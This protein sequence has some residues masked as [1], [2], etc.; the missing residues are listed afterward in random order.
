[1][2][3]GD[4]LLSD[5]AI[6]FPMATEI[7]RKNRLD[8]CCGGKQTLKDACSKRQIDLENIVAQLAELKP[9]NTPNVSELPLD[10]MTSFIVKRFHEDL[11]KRLPELCFLSQ[12]VERVHHDH[13][14]C[15]HG[16]SQ[17]L[18]EF[19]KEMLFH[20]MKEENVLFPLI[21]EGRG[22]MALMPVKVMMIDHDSHGKQLEEIHRLTSDFHPP[23]DACTSWKS[24]YRGL[25]ELEAELME[26]IHLENNVLFPRALGQ[27]K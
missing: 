6:S 17:L 21:N 2:N 16:L 1:M 24:L 5:L 14:N 20:M 15:P 22:H 26:H 18:V 13:E 10:E 19:E 4:Q 25:E 11:R 9:V 27:G 7:F 23:A 8:F 3:Y 12:K